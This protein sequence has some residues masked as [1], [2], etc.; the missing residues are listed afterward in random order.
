MNALLKLRC[1]GVQVDRTVPQIASQRERSRDL[2]LGP[3]TGQRVGRKFG[4]D[5]RP[6]Y[7]GSRA[8]PRMCGWRSSMIGRRQAG[9]DVAGVVRG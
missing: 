3:A 5:A 6:A 1:A 4:L 9:A 2:R 7:S 8:P